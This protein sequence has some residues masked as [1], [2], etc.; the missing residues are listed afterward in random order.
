MGRE[1]TSRL[2]R[3]R[4]A[5]LIVAALLVALLAV[6]ATLLRTTSGTQGLGRFYVGIWR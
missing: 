6:G 1:Q 2:P 3:R 4:R 5:V